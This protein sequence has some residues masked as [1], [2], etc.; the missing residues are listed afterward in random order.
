MIKQNALRSVINWDRL[1]ARLCH[2]VAAR[3]TH[4]WQL[5][6]SQ[7]HRHL[8]II[9]SLTERVFFISTVNDCSKKRRKEAYFALR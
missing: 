2:L 5:L 9:D 1:A 7:K 8:K 4:F 3:A 6:V